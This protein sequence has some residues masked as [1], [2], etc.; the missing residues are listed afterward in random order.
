MIFGYGEYR[1]RRSV[2]GPA[3]SDES[4]EETERRQNGRMKTAKQSG[5]Q[6]IENTR[7]REIADFALQ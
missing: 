3:G 5:A 2:D 6:A 7:F 4:Q 1:S